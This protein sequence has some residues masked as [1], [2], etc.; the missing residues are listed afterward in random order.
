LW[1]PAEQDKKSHV[2]E[3]RRGSNNRVISLDNYF[4]G[5]VDNHIASAEYRRGHTKDI[6]ALIPEKPDTFSSGQYVRIAPRSTTCGLLPHEY[7]RHVRRHGILSVQ[8]YR[9]WF[10]PR[11][12]KFA[13]G[14]TAVKIRIP[15]RNPPTS[16]SSSTMAAGIC[17]TRFVTSITASVRA[18]EGG[19]YDGDRQVRAAYLQARL[20]RWLRPGLKNAFTY[21]KDLLGN[22]LGE[23]G[24]VW[25]YAGI[26]N[27]QSCRSP[28][29]WR[30][31]AWSKVMQAEESP[32]IPPS[33]QGSR[34]GADD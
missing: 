7:D 6:E 4:N 8:L 21:V 24:S 17:L 10:T 20:S 16:I 11:Q 25:P 30:P 19:K 32:T 31:R 2:I 33:S 14:A 5:S 3:M 22:I 18:R 12:H 26:S 23:K 28:R 13:I 27:I 9:S 34:L 1:L 29:P 15:S